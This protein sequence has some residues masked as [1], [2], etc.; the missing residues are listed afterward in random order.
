M[1]RRARV[2]PARPGSAAGGAQAI[3]LPAPQ[4]WSPFFIALCVLLLTGIWRMQNHIGLVGSLRLPML[5]SLF[6]YGLFVWDASNRRE[7]GRLSRNRIM[8]L[9][10]VF[11]GLMLL[12]VPAAINPYKAFGFIRAD[13][14]KNLILMVMIA[15][16][17]RRTV[18]VQRLMTIMVG[19]SIVYSLFELR[20]ANYGSN[21]RLLMLGYYDANDFAFVLVIT[22]PMIVYF[23]QRHFPLRVRLLA[24]VGLLVLVY[25]ITRTGSRG[26]F[27]AIVA[28]V[29]YMSLRA[30]ALPRKM[31]TAVVAVL[32]GGLMVVGSAQYW[33][34][35]ESIFNPSE[36]YNVTSETGRIEVWKRG[37][38]YMAH[39]PLTG[40]GVANFENAEGLLSERAQENMAMGVGT[41][42]TSPHNSF[43]EV[44]AEMGIL[45]FI[46]Q[47]LMLT[48]SLTK[49]R[50][51]ER[52]GTLANGRAPP[53]MAIAQTLQASFIGYIVAGFFLSQGFAAYLQVLFGLTMG[54]EKV[55]AVEAGGSRPFAAARG[56]RPVG[57][58]MRRGPLAL[59]RPR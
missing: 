54:L 17:V 2:G 12:S 37:L 28:V 29:G 19:G 47:V 25:S 50:R 39:N 48:T 8:Q 10:L 6:A 41:R 13:H 15:A 51:L 40:V 3:G 14:I 21:G 58:R 56:A 43:V 18:D 49:L 34:L 20:S 1:A 11:L 53:N 38:S 23:L 59:A 5:A 44:A 7:V 52:A 31:R 35:M 4:S 46:V 57:R 33:S 30:T 22:L 26:G 9:A 36:D 16:A 32:A 24:A 45:G 27:L 42:W 55:G